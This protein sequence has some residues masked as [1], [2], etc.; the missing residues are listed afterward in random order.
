[1]ITSRLSNEDIIARSWSFFWTKR[2]I[3]GRRFDSLPFHVR[4]AVWYHE[5]GHIEMHHVEKGLLCLLLTPWRF[6]KLCRQQELDADQYAAERGHA[7]GLIELLRFE[8]DQTF[9]H[10]SN[11][12]R[13]QHLKQY[14]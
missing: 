6:F 4:N 10:P 2:I 3:V 7:R 11:S 5:T 1:M 9:S 14:E 13:R 8:K 12:E